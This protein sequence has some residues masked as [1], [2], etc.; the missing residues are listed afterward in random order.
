MFL[1]DEFCLELKPFVFI[2]NIWNHLSECK[3]MIIC[4]QIVSV[5]AM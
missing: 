3:Q 5:I 2:S 1:F 4:T